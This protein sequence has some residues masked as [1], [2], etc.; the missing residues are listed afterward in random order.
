[1]YIQDQVSI[2]ELDDEHLSFF[3]AIGVDSIHLDLRGGAPTAG[4]R[5]GTGSANTSLAQDLKAGKD[6]TD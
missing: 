2:G 3:R 4:R 6:C 5:G 1:M